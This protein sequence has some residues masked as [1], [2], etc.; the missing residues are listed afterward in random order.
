MTTFVLSTTLGVHVPSLLPWGVGGSGLLPGGVP[1]CQGTPQN[2]PGPGE[3]A[4]RCLKHSVSVCTAVCRLREWLIVYIAHIIRFLCM[5]DW[6]LEGHRELS[7]YVH[8]QSWWISPCNS[9][10]SSMVYWHI[11]FITLLQVLV[12]TGHTFIKEAVTLDTKKYLSRMYA[13]MHI[14]CIR[15]V[16]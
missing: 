10:T 3:G 13:C 12:Q 7:I 16:W 4:G 1:Q 8:Q 5:W 15:I 14:M 2:A 9:L 6:A 11:N